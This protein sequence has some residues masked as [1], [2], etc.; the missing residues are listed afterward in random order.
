MNKLIVKDYKQQFREENNSNFSKN[1]TA[2]LE[3]NGKNYFYT[4]GQAD[5]GEFIEVRN[6][7]NILI[8]D[9]CK[10]YKK[11]TN[12]QSLINKKEISKDF[13]NKL[14]KNKEEKERFARENYF[15]KKSNED[16]FILVSDSTNMK[17]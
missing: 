8:L 9:I 17:K 7:N 6:E 15:M 16:I 2:T 11:F 3:Y 4:G 13:Y 5:F 10:I 1:I 12:H 14:M